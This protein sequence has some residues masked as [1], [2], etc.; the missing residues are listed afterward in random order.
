MTA[1]IRCGREFSLDDFLGHAVTCYDIPSEPFILQC[2][3]TL[4]KADVRE[5]RLAPGIVFD[6]DAL[7]LRTRG[8]EQRL[9]GREGLLLRQLIDNPRHVLTRAQL[10]SAVWGNERIVNEREVDTYIYRLREHLRRA[11]DGERLIIT[12]RDVGYAYNPS[13]MNVDEDPCSNYGG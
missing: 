4:A 10:L 2:V 6:R 5:V 8:T 9:T 1:C 11:P 12:V 7:V 13:A 3:V